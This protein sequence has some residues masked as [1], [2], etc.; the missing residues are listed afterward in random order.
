MA[1]LWTFNCIRCGETKQEARANSDCSRECYQCKNEI[2]DKSEREWRAGREDLTIEERL[3]DLETFMYNHGSHKFDL[4][5]IL[6]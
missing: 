5:S 6:F 3:R 2:K 1:R 4:N